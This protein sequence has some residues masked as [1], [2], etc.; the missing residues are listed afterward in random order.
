MI[1]YGQIYNNQRNC[2]YSL[3]KIKKCVQINHYTILDLFQIK[4][5]ILVID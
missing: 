3:K 2:Y 1:I 4:P 5:H